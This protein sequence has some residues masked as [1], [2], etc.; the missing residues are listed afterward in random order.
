MGSFLFFLR[1]MYIP[2]NETMVKLRKELLWKQITKQ[3][4]EEALK[5]S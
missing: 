5:T 4:Q 1:I 3:A 2:F